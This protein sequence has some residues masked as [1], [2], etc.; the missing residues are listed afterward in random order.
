MGVESDTYFDVGT[1]SIEEKVPREVFLL[2]HPMQSGLFWSLSE[3]SMRS[4]TVL[5]QVL[6]VPLSPLLK[7]YR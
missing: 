1:L 6:H 2:G 7:T 5:E 3:G 4:P